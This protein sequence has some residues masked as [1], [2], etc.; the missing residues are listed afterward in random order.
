MAG[1]GPPA[2]AQVLHRVGIA[3]GVLDGVVEALEPLG[4]EREED[5]V[6][7]G[8]VAVDRRR[9]V[10]D[11]LSDLADRD[12]GVAFRHEQIARGGENGGAHRMPLPVLSFSDAHRPQSD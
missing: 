11:A 8:E 7:A 1:T 12:V 2:V 4:G 5:V 9:A 10:L 3:G 6:L